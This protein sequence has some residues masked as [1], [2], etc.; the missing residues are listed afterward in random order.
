MLAPPARRLDL[1]REIDLIEEVARLVGFDRF[2]AQ[3]PHPVA[4]GALTAQQRAERQLRQLFSAAGLQEITTLSLVGA[5]S[6][7]QRIAISNPL[8][9]ETSHLRTNLWEE[10]LAVCLRNLKASQDGCWVFEIGTTYSGSP[11]DVVETRQL[12]G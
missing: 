9:A 1:A 3:L 4:P 5:G 6:S 2:G 12:C 11:I 7:E 8:L 10:H